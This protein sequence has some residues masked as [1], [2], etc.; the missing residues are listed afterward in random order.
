MMFEPFRPFIAADFQVKFA[1]ATWERRCAAALRRQVFCE[2]QGLFGSDDRDAL[3]DVAIPIVALSLLGVMA[4]DVVGTVRIHESAPGIW[5]GSR[6]AVAAPYRKVGAL[7]AALIRLAVSSAHA[8]GATSFFAH[9]QSQN[10]LL[11]RRLHWN[12]IEETERHGRPHALM[13]ADLAFYPP[14][15]DAE[16][17]FHAQ[18]RAALAGSA[19]MRRAA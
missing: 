19:S 17:G 1:T 7:G 16:T 4:D 11:F 8:R 5:W 12:L 18:A 6:L 15:A 9:V 10:A 2:E 13:Q 3:D 14:I